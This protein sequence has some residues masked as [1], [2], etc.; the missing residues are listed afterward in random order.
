MA[1]VWACLLSAMKLLSAI[2]RI[3]NL[4]LF[5]LPVV[6]LMQL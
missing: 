2:K 3:R 4:L 6:T 1:K 5:Q